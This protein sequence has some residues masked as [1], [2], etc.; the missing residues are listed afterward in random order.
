MQKTQPTVDFQKNVDQWIKDFNKTVTELQDVPDL[1]EEQEGNINHNY[2]LL[3]EIKEEVK[4]LKE[5]LKTLKLV[6]TVMLK[7]KLIK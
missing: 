7:E 3:L 4:D 5:D 1:L 6:Q 2:E